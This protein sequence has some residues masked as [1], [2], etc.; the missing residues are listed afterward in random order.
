[1]PCLFPFFG[2]VRFHAFQKPIDSLSEI[3]GKKQNIN[4]ALLIFEN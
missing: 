4:D 1:M 3:W 2:R